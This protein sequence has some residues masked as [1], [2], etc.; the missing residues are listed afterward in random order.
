MKKM[1]SDFEQKL[2]DLQGEKDALD[3]EKQQVVTEK[4]N[5]EAEVSQLTGEVM[6]EGR[7]QSACNCP[8]QPLSAQVLELESVILLLRREQLLLGRWDIFFK[9]FVVFGFVLGVI[10]HNKKFRKYRKT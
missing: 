9:A 8:P 6:S 5:L 3:S 10:I 4:Q 7:K 1:E 2:Q